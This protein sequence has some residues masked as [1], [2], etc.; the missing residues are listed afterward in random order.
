M[1]NSVGYDATFLIPENDDGEEPE[2]CPKCQA[3]MDWD[4]RL[5][6]CPECGAVVAFDG[7]DDNLAD[8]IEEF[9][10]EEAR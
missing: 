2:V 6:R 5:W 8:L 7:A 1:P 10:E 4:G 3:Y 9:E